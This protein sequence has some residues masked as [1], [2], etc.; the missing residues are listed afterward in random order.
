MSMNRVKVLLFATLREHAR[1][2]SIMM[3]LPEGMDIQGL[4]DRLS[5]EYPALRQDLKTVLVSMNKEYAPE[6]A[7]IPIEAEIALFPPVSGG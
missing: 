4:I 1:A 7:V 5:V 2:K 3:E 6:N